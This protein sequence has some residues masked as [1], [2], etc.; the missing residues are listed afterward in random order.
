MSCKMAKND[1]WHGLATQQ[2]A[3]KWLDA[4]SVAHG[5]LLGHPQK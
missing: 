1:G 2:Y 3:L 4:L 5:R